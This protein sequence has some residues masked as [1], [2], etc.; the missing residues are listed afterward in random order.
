MIGAR[1]DLETMTGRPVRYFAFPYGQYHNLTSESFE[2][3]HRSGYRG[4]C[5]AYGGYNFPGDNPFH[6]QRIHPDNDLL[7]LKNW[8][9]VDPRK[10]RGVPPIRRP[11]AADGH[12]SA[13]S[14]GDSRVIPI[15]P[16]RFFGRPPT[17]FPTSARAGPHAGAASGTGDARTV[18]DARPGA[19]GHGRIVAGVGVDGGRHAG[20]QRDVDVGR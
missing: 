11:S 3:A 17:T 14:A 7:H 15:C 20:D 10:L 6:L 4:V 9:T 13:G 16:S 12:L 5:S 18:A 1:Q 19:A 2:L 8:L